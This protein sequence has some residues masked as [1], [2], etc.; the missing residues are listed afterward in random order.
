MYGED[1]IPEGYEPA[2]LGPGGLDPNE[3]F[4]TLPAPMQLAF[5]SQDV[6]K[7][8]EA[9]AR[10][11]PEEGAY[12]LQRCVDS[13]LWVENAGGLGKEEKEEEEEGAGGGEE[14]KGVAGDSQKKAVSGDRG[15]KE[16]CIDAPPELADEDMLD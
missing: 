15:K 5:E 14:G 12:H 1:G 2:G 10:L 4:Q 13:G 7:L 3:V 16:A 8:K 11:P 9:L 6:G